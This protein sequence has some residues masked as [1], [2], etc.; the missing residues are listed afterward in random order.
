MTNEEWIKKAADRLV[1]RNKVKEDKLRNPIIQDAKVVYFEIE[2]D[3]N[4]MMVLDSQTGEQLFAQFG[5]ERFLKQ[6]PSRTS[7]A[8]EG[9]HL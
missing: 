2:P 7:R 3:S 1:T 4:V 6:G 9:P 5:P 8:T